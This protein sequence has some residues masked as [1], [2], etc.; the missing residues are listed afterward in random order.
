MQEC[1]LYVG[2]VSK[3]FWTDILFVS[4][5]YSEHQLQN[6]M[7]YGNDSSKANVSSVKKC[8]LKHLIISW[9][10]SEISNN[11]KWPKT[12]ALLVYIHTQVRLKFTAKAI[13]KSIKYNTQF[14]KMQSSIIV[15]STIK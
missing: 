8:N 15:F 12:F 3:N 2:E 14:I 5:S 1:S 7:R 10:L 4:S 11:L 6:I 13:L 9:Q